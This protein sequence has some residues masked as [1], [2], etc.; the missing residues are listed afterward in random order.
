MNCWNIVIISRKDYM[1]IFS[2]DRRL[3]SWNIT[4]LTIV[5][6]TFSSFLVFSTQAVHV[7]NCWPIS[8]VLMN[9]WIVC[10]VIRIVDRLKNSLWK[11]GFGRKMFLGC[12][13]VSGCVVYTTF[14]NKLVLYLISVVPVLKTQLEGPGAST[15]SLLPLLEGNS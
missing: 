15:L 8:S 6:E 12:L 2:N 3:H 7:Q 5:Y 9:K 1:L 14:Y 4:I 11:D 13:H 10:V